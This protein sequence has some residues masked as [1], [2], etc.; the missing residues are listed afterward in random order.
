MLAFDKSIRDIA[1]YAA[2]VSY[3]DLASEVV[4]AVKNRVVDTLGCGI[5]AF[6]SEPAKIARRLA[7]PIHSVPNARVIG[8]LVR[9][10]P[11]CA[12]FANAL[13]CRYFDLNDSYQWIG[14]GHPSDAISGILAAGE[15]F[16]TNGKDFITS[17]ALAFDVQCYFIEQLQIRDRGWDH[18]FYVTLGTAIGAGKLIGLDLEELCN[19][20]SLSIVPNIYLDQRRRGELSMWKAGATGNAARQGLFAA[21]LA[22][23]GMTGPP[24]AIEGIDGLWNR[25]TGPFNL[26]SLVQKGKAARITKTSIKQWPV[27][28]SIQLPIATALQLREKLNGERTCELRLETYNKAVKYNISPEQWAPKNRETADHSLPYCVAAAIMDGEVTS[29]TF[30]SERLQDPKLLGLMT[31]LQIEENPEFTKVFPRVESCRLTATTESGKTISAF[32]QWTEDDRSKWATR[33]SIE[34]KF[35]RLT[36]DFL[37]EERRKGFLDYVYVMENSKDVGVL[38]DNL[39]I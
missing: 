4:L 3:E 7:V 10:T 31:R 37:T 6:N 1:D 25:V 35:N 11:E 21:L 19:C 23:A 38:L 9:T 27:R 13:M 29:K 33:Q 32:L 30:S 2:S 24:C 36:N 17:I 5:A 39:Y 12:A 26:D 15:A 14:G 22:Q 34:A 8:S 28:G 20:I 16:H 18:E